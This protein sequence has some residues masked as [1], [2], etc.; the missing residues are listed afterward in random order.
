MAFSDRARSGKA[1]SRSAPGRT[2]LLQR[3]DGAFVLAVAKEQL[4]ERAA[5]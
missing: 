5:R 3:F 4:G 1:R 2:H